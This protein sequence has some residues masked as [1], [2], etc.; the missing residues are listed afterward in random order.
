MEESDLEFVNNIRNDIT[1]RKN[2]RNSDLI[3]LEETLKWFHDRKP[4]WFIIKVGGDRVGYMRTSLNTGESICIGCDIHPDHR[5]KGYAKSAYNLLMDDFYS[6]GYV[7]LWLEVFRDNTVAYNLY[8][9]LGF[10][11]AGPP[12]RIVDGREYVT[13]VH[14]RLDHA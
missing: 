1:T 7:L 4:M 9:K 10:I 6:L 13:M 14:V 8:K 2:L 12:P 3:S 5:G 11:E